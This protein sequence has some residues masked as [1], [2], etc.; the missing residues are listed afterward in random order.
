MMTHLPLTPLL[1]PMDQAEAI[2][3]GLP[4]SCVP[5]PLAPI[6]NLPLGQ[7]TT[8][9]TLPGVVGSLARANALGPWDWP[10][11]PVI[12]IS[13]LH[14]D[15][16]SLLRSLTAARAIQRNGD[17]LSDFHLTPFGRS[18]QFIIGGDCLDKGPSNLDLLDSLSALLKT[19]ADVVILAGNHDLRLY[20]GLEALTVKRS[21]LNA[22]MFVRMGKKVMPLLKEVHERYVGS[23]ANLAMLPDEETC[24]SLM[25]PGKKWTRQF[26]KAASRYL[27]DA[28][29]RKE[30]QRLKK[31]AD[32]F[33]EHAAEVGLT[34][35]QLYAAALK[36]RELFVEPGGRYAWFFQSLKAVHQ[37]GS[38]LFVHAGID[39]HMASQISAKGVAHVNRRFR[40]ESRKDPFVFYSGTIA[41]LMRTKYRDVDHPL[42]ETGVDDLH[43]A[44]IRM[45]VQG[46]VN[47][48]SGQ[49]LTSKHGLLHLEADIT[50]DRHSRSSE[51]LEG[52]GTG[53]TIICP[54][55]NIVGI[56]RD[57]PH[58]KLF[59]PAHI[60]QQHGLSS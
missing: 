43:L 42:T 48:H 7:F 23:S 39:D 40:K 46:H 13:D 3:L 12:F 36:C 9:S 11:K 21:S 8:E 58:A 55:G 24:L 59:N 28:A 14:A 1:P 19:G 54:D 18:C 38:L 29:I 53:A 25:V 34:T 10:E 15:A 60:L 50:L 57:Y 22:H 37:S 17:G 51:G 31:K 30:M 4:E 49:E 35:R 47:R 44:G 56:S 20:L 52:I 2:D 27:S 45:L 16:E 32:K 5:W 41:N 26:P 33:A 6:G